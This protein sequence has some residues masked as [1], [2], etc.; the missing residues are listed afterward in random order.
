MLAITISIFLGVTA[1]LVA[2]VLGMS[3]S[4]AMHGYGSICRELEAIDRRSR[5]AL[6]SRAVNRSGAT[7]RTARAN[8]AV[9]EEF[10]PLWTHG[11]CA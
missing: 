2:W 1:I 3:A 8:P 10:A 9:R 7:V 11:A 4:Q 6:G 5:A